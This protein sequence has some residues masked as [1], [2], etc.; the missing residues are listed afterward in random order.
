MVSGLVFFRKGY[1]GG[2]FQ[3]VAKYGGVVNHLLTWI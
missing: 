3:K 2:A 1:N